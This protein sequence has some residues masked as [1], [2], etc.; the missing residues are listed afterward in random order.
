MLREIM[1]REIKRVQEGLDPMGVIRDPNKHVMIDTK[2]MQ[3]IEQM[4]E[5]RAPRAVNE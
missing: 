1:M 4:G 3:S 2:L 5:S